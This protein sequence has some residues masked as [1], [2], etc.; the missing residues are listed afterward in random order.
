MKDIQLLFKCSFKLGDAESK[1]QICTTHT[2]LNLFIAGA[3]FNKLERFTYG[4]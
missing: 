4:T 1:N 3:V 2:V